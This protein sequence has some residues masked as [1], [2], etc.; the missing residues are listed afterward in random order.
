MDVRSPRHPPVQRF[1]TPSSYHVS[2]LRPPEDHTEAPYGIRG[3][4]RLRR[5]AKMRLMYVRYII[6]MGDDLSDGIS[7]NRYEALRELRA[8][9]TRAIERTERID[10]DTF[11]ALMNESPAVDPRDRPDRR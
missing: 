6:E 1:N 8:K 5:V 11:I 3:S 2:K 10:D 7:V 9:A 4:A